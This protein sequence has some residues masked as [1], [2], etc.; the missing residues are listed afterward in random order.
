MN[1]KLFG[2]LAPAF[3]IFSLTSCNSNI[4]VF[5]MNDMACVNYLAAK[6]SKAQF[7][8]I[9]HNISSRTGVAHDISLPYTISCPTDGSEE[10]YF[11]IANN[12]EF[13]NE[14]IIT[15][16]DSELAYSNLIPGKTYYWKIYGNK[17]DNVLKAGN[18]TVNKDNV[19]W[20]NAPSVGNMRDLG[21][22]D[23]PGGK[24]IKFGKVFR[25]RNPDEINETDKALLKDTLGIKTQLDFRKDKA[26]Y[27]KKEAFAEG[28]SYNYYN[29]GLTYADII[30]KVENP[31]VG[32][33]ILPGS[34]LSG[35]TLTGIQMFQDIFDKLANPDN[36]PIYFHCSA[37]ADRTGALA[38]F[39]EALLGVTYDD[40]VRD[41]ELTSFSPYITGGRLRCDHNEDKTDFDYTKDYYET[42]DESDYKPTWP[43]LIAALK[44]INE[45]INVAVETFLRDKCQ[46]PQETL[47]QVKENLTEEI[48]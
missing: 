8:A 22:W 25:A 13:K 37:G 15:R 20:I 44:G 45:N 43:R 28:V 14:E 48:K 18:F 47:N 38:F 41:F 30:N 31:L 4:Q 2:I 27:P 17:T 40:I 19:R 42:H 46:I 3:L 29:D 7:N 12:S 35:Q 23:L 33:C 26:P 36:Y 1:R 9:Y 32:P 34:P 21:G 24:Q 10:Y 16:T 6:T 11:H 5:N 39:I